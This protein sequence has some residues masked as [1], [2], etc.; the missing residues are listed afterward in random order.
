[1]K[2]YTIDIA[3]HLENVE[4]TVKNGR[5]FEH[6]AITGT[7]K[8]FYIDVAEKDLKRVKQYAI[9]HGNDKS[10]C[11]GSWYAHCNGYAMDLCVT[12]AG[13]YISIN[14]YRPYGRTDKK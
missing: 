2:T 12:N 4:I 8:T 9:K 10:S 13:K 6:C 14:T 11:R 3:P 7:Y 1:M 5:L